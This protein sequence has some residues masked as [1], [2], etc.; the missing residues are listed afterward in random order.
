MDK[1][2]TYIALLCGIN[3]GGHR[4]LKM[5][6]LRDMFRHLGFKN[7]VSYIQSGNVIFDAPEQDEDQLANE[8]QKQIEVTFGYEV[9]VIIFSSTDLKVILEQFPFEEKEGWREYIT[10][11][12][13][14][15]SKEQIERLET[16]SSDIE[17]FQVA[18]RAVYIHIDKQSDQKPLFSSSFIQK[19][20]NIPATNRNLRSVNKIWE[21]AS[22]SEKKSQV[23]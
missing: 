2:P 16:L 8:I 22:S 13:D 19:Q 17:T 10:F 14:Q 3:V 4:P 7:V 9:P 11:L 20:L 12:S 6:N 23:C 15:P 21:L 5:N 1:H 18:N